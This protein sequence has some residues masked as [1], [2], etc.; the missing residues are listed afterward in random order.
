MP[1]KKLG[2]EYMLWVESSTPNTFNPI[3]G[4]GN[5]SITRSSGSIDTTSKDDGGYGTAAPGPK[6]LSLGLEIIPKLPD[7]TGYTR[8]ET[9]CNASPVLPFNVQVRKGGLTGTDA[10]AVFEG[11]VYGNLDDTSYNQ[12]D[13]VKVRATFSAA[14]APVTDILA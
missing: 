12:G 10:D 14:S 11:S 3:L 2:S 8:L 13:A 7:A 4:Q 5:L 9:L 6:A 1:T